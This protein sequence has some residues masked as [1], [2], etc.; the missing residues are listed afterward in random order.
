MIVRVLQAIERLE[1]RAMV[2]IAGAPASGKSTLAEAVV[3]SLGDRAALVPMD[4]FHLDDAV[5]ED[6]GH[7]DRKG[8]PWT[9]DTGGFLSVLERLKRREEV[10]VP[11]FDRG[12][13]L[14]RAGA[15]VISPE[16]E[17][18]V[19][20]G[21][22]LLL[23]EDPWRGMRPIYDLTVLLDMPV[24]VLEARLRARWDQYGKADAEG[25]IA[26]NDLPNA[27][28]VADRSGGADITLP[29]E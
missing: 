29:P 28:I 11:V 10:A 15:R 3:A 23:D 8:A 2:A 27:R 12:L 20:E 13:E 6:R 16:V 9:Y 24:E 26:A 4:G 7:R 1:P 22:Y 14:A 25:W 17:V 18:V 5:L 19:V 21:N